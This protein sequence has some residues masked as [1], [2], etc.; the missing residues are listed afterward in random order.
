MEQMMDKK[1]AAA[2]LNVSQRT[3]DYFR[4]RGGLPFHVVGGENGK[5][6]RFFESEL[7]DWILGRNT[8]KDNKD[9]NNKEETK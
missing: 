1:Q 7:R 3:V 2:F 9:S 6:V 4:S 8:D 5:L